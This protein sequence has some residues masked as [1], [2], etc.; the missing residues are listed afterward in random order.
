VLLLLSASCF[1]AGRVWPM[2]PAPVGAPDAGAAPGVAAFVDRPSMLAHRTV[3]IESIRVGDRVLAHNPLGPEDAAFTEPDPA[4]WRHVVMRHRHEDDRI[5][6]VSLLRPRDWLTDHRIAPHAFVDLHMPELGVDGRA[7]VVAVNPCPRIDSGEGAIVTGTFIHELPK[8]ELLLEVA[9]EGSDTPITATA[10]HPFFSPSR[11]A[12]LPLNHFAPG[13]RLRTADGQLLRITNITPRGPPAKTKVYNLE[14]AVEHVYHVG[15]AGVL[16]HNKALHADAA[17]PGPRGPITDPSRLLPVR[18]LHKHHLFPRQFR[19]WFARNGIDIERY[20][21][22]LDQT[23]HLRGIHGRGV[24]PGYADFPGEWNKRWQAFVK[25][26]A[27]PMDTKRIFQ[28]LGRMMDEFRLND[29]VI[30]AE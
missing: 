17:L 3:A 24:V 27:G 23:T 8:G 1:V 28:E 15:A 26:D 21:I 29:Y 11:Q 22:R 10:N 13:D 19:E 30:I 9:I 7:Y 14:V 5:T 4:T 20:K 18:P 2:A 16:V 25:G 6:I 12:F